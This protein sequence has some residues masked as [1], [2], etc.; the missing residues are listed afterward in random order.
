MLRDVIV[1]RGGGRDAPNSADEEGRR[2][3]EEKLARHCKLRE[4][5]SLNEA[6]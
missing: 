3:T 4:V 1:R 5:M 2:Q 6:S